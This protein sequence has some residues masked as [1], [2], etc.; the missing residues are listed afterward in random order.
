MA[1]GSSRQ[2]VKLNDSRYNMVLL[3]DIESHTTYA[4]IIITINNV[5]KSIK[6]IIKTLYFKKRVNTVKVDTTL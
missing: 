3:P 2:L 1:A 4:T 6:N 5:F